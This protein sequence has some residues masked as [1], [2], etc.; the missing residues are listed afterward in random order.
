MWDD[1]A[2][3]YHWNPQE[4]P[5]S[6]EDVPAHYWLTVELQP[7]PSASVTALLGDRCPVWSC[8]HLCSCYT[9]DMH[10]PRINRCVRCRLEGL[11]A[12]SSAAAAGAVHV[13]LD[14]SATAPCHQ[15]GTQQLSHIQQLAQQLQNPTSHPTPTPRHACFTDPAAVVHFAKFYVCAADLHSLHR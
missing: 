13:L 4:Q 8:L 14:G 11:H 2:W 6:P 10:G 5:W 1:G 3:P 7:Q 15:G 9:V 12:G